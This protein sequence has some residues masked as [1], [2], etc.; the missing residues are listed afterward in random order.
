MG[1]PL[2][3]RRTQGRRLSDSRNER[4]LRGLLHDLGHE[5]TTLSYLIEAVRGDQTLPDDS[6]Y[7]LELVSLEMSRLRDIIQQGLSG[8]VG[9]SAEAVS[10]TG[11]ATQLTRLAE[12]AYEADVSLAPGDEVTATIDPL[13]LWRVLSN[14]VD[15]AARAAGP[16]GRVILTV[17]ADNGAVIEVTDDGPGF[18]AGPP[19]TA[20][21]G[22]GIVRSLLEACGG[23]LAVHAPP[24]G[25]TTV[26]VSVPQQDA[27]P[28][29][30]A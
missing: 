24:G 1:S 19:G 28:L 27:A 8:E 20:S 2:E 18:G 3:R 23:S 6:G 4:A 9:G 11:L 5:I 13:L 17:R 15:N 16:R 14:V 30:I 29:G 12:L 22:L 10:V 7:R 25:G 26:Q 21:L